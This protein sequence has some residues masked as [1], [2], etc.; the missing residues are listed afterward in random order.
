MAPGLACETVEPIGHPERSRDHMKNSL[1]SALHSTQVWAYVGATLFLAALLVSAIEYPE[2]RL[3]HTFQ[4]LIYIVVIVLV[5]WNSA[6]GYGAGFAVAI[7]WNAV[8]LF[9][10]HLIQVGAVAF[11]SSLR[12]GHVQQLVPMMV[13]LGGIG[14]FILIVAALFAVVGHNTEVRRWWKFAGGGVLSVA[15]FAVLIVIFGHH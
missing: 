5:R 12:T 11:W 8:G 7:V 13:T 4:A 6:W 2:L 9:V 14:H 15:Y 10:S 3:L 1:P